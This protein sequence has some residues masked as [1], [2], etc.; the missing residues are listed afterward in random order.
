M[1]V[2]RKSIE[3]YCEYMADGYCERC[4]FCVPCKFVNS[5]K[6]PKDMGD[7]DID[8]LFY[9]AMHFY[10]EMSQ[11]LSSVEKKNKE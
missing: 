1:D 10:D 9:A 7:R 8:L 2:F 6:T 11:V 3:Q 5:D 4:A